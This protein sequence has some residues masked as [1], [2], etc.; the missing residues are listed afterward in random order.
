MMNPTAV[1][2]LLAV[3]LLLN[4]DLKGEKQRRVCSAKPTHGSSLALISPPIL[5]LSNI[6]RQGLNQRIWIS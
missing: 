4:T 6:G 2:L 1:P 3:W 5:V